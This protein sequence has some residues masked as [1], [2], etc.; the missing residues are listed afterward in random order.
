MQVLYYNNSDTTPARPGTSHLEF[1]S[2]AFGRGK[3]L[4]NALAK[5]YEF[6][7]LRVFFKGL[8]FSMASI[9]HFHIG[10]FK[11]P[12]TVF[13]NMLNP[14]PIQFSGSALS[15]MSLLRLGN[16]RET[17]ICISFVCTAIYHLMKFGSGAPPPPGLYEH[18]SVFFMERT[19]FQLKFWKRFSS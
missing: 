10:S 2:C 15:T 1:K 3:V 11:N 14:R 9:F 18:P 12:A 4:S 13:K 16:K 6:Q 8:R 5:K 17:A 7:N 19:R